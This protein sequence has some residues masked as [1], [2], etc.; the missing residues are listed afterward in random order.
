MVT[1]S[2]S[3]VFTEALRATLE[4]EAARG[5]EAA[6]D[7]R[8]ILAALPKVL[9]PPKPGPLRTVAA[10]HLDGALGRANGTPMEALARVFSPI[11]RASGWLSTDGYRA[12]GMDQRFF[13]NY[14]YVKYMGPGTNAPD[15]GISAGCTM[16]GP[17]IHYPAHAHPARE[18]YLVLSGTAEWRRDVEPWAA[19]APGAFIVHP[20]MM[21]HAMRTGGEALL[22]LYF[23]TGDLVTESRLVPGG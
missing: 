2:Q 7:C 4:A 10:N 23:W 22:A 12:Q 17:H 15:R 11:I 5:G 13:D 21:T 1:T 19:R 16:L 20:S 18:L 6:G 14:G 8:T 3:A 9:P